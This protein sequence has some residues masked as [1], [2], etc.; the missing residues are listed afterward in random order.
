MKRIALWLVTAVLLL[1]LVGCGGYTSHY[2]AV[3][4]VH[5]NE[6][7]E[8][9]MNF[10]SFE[11][12]MVFKM[13]C[14][15][16]GAKLRASAALESGSAAVYYDENGT[17]TALCTVQAGEETEL[18]ADLSGTGTVYV[19]VETSEKCGNGEFRFSI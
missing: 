12:T 3:G 16:P 4:F 10:Y 2:K 9:F 7:D 1:S 6:S 13:K 15:E 19:I 11:G 17:K 14:K 18:S 8:A 5:S